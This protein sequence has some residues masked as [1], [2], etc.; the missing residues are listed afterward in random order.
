MTPKQYAELLEYIQKNNSWAKMLDCAKKNRR[1][2]KYI[3]A[4]FDT[5][6]GNIW[7]LTFRTGGY[8]KEFRVDEPKDIKMVYEYLDEKI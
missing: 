8:R 4:I 7:H 6:T 1:V 3:D 5:R 2:I